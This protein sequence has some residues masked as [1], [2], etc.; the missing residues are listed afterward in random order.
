MCFIYLQNSSPEV[1]VFVNGENNP[2][3]G[4]IECLTATFLHTHHS[5][6]AKL[7]R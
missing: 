5:L 7:G 3:H 6:L 2:N 4:F 1:E